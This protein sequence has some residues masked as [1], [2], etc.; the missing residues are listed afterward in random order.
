MQ[1]IGI[2]T[3]SLEHQIP[4]LL[5]SD[6]EH[7]GE[8][9]SAVKA[10]VASGEG[11]KIYTVTTE[12]VNIVLPHLNISASVKDEIRVSVAIGKE[13]IV[14]QNNIVIGDWTGIGYIITDPETGA[15][16]YRISG[17]SN[18]A[19][20]MGFFSGYFLTVMIVA[21]NIPGAGPVAA[22]A[23]LMLGL[24]LG[25]GIFLMQENRIC[26]LPWFFLGGFLCGVAVVGGGIAAF[27][28]F[29]NLISRALALFFARL[30]AVAFIHSLP[31]LFG[32]L[33]C[34]V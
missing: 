25:F 32:Y 4:E 28:A 17:G 30:G 26:Q 24:M 10:A 34:Y 8:A 12:N 2:L 9:V 16:A 22:I 27:A 23:A 21:A 11:Q 29:A 15:G 13:A 31:V 33:P 7:P 19:H 14:S 3:S 1:Q 20:Y 6:T 18:G 5:F